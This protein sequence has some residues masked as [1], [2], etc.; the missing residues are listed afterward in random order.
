MIMVIN[1]TLTIQKLKT[2]LGDEQ[3]TDNP[4]DLLCYSKDSSIESGKPNVVVFPKTT[5]EVV[6][7]I[8]LAVSE[9][10]PIIPRGAGSNVS[11]G[12]IATKKG[13]IIVC[14]TRMNKILELD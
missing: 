9:K 3:V 14:M 5:Q 13:G 6:E 10:V 1:W 8:K 2:L 4:L 7:I 12:V 11:G